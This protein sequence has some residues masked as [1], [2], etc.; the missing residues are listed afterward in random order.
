MTAAV[1]TP[2]VAQPKWQLWVGRVLSALPV[3]GL[4]MSA[5]MKVAGKPEATEMFVSKLGYQATLLPKLAVL[6]L[7]CTILYVIPQTAVLGAVLLTGYL[8]GAVA[9]HVRVGEPFMA[10][11]LLGVMLWAGLFLRDPR[12]RALLPLRR[13]I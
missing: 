8:G 3:L 4:L 5:S 6:E 1:I 2:A 12:I 7:V 13:S 11:V 9:T 10:P